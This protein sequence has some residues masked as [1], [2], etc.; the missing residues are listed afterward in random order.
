[1]CCSSVAHKHTSVF[2]AADGRERENSDA[3]SNSL[4]LPFLFD[5]CPTESPGGRRISPASRRREKE[6]RERV[7]SPVLTHMID[8][9]LGTANTGTQRGRHSQLQTGK[10]HTHERKGKERRE[11]TSFFMLHNLSAPQTCSVFTSRLFSL[12]L[13]FPFLMYDTS[14]KTKFWPDSCYLCLC[15]LVALG[16]RVQLF[17]W[18]GS[19]RQ[20]RERPK[21]CEIQT[22][23]L[24]ITGQPTHVPRSNKA[25]L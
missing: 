19:G 22:A 17:W 25:G 14:G 9:S 23:S 7:R 5:S 6:R 15:L 8:E 16:S 12:F 21:E 4:L 1:M 11:R 20:N 3:P 10:K 18:T 2:Y 13:T 24:T